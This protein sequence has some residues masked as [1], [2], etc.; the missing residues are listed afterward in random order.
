GS[1]KEGRVRKRRIEIT[2]IRCRRT[3]ILQQRPGAEREWVEHSNSCEEE[4]IPVEAVSSPAMRLLI[5]ALLEGEGDSRRAAERLGISRA[6][7]Y[8]KLRR[9]GLSVRYL[10]SKL[11]FFRDRQSDRRV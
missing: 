2:A 4:A 8:S 11:N 6:S 10:K 1:T 7:F 5:E 3:M 9:L